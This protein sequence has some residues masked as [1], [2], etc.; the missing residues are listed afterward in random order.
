MIVKALRKK[1]SNEFINIVKYDN[2]HVV[3]ISEI[4]VVS[5]NSSTIEKLQLEYP[6]VDMAMFEL[7][8]LE[9]NEI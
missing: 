6:A 9:I 7:I 5:P 8:E 1:N 4:P 3:F 2:G